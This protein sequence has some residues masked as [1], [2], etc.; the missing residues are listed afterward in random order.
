[1][2]RFGKLGQA[3]LRNKVMKPEPEK[4]KTKQDILILLKHPTI[5]AIGFWAKSQD[6][7]IIK[8]S[9]NRPIAARI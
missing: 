3:S 7:K 6:K 4:K 8:I 1:M 9:I 2:V 5:L